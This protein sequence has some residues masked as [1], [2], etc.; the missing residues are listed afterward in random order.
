MAEHQEHTHNDP[1][2]AG[3][4]YDGIREYDNPIPGW[5]H[6]IFYGSVVFSLLYVMVVHMSPMWPTRNEA[7]DAAEERALEIQFAELRTFPMGEDKV[8]RIMGQ[9]KWL[10][11]GANIFE[12]NCALCHKADGSGMEG[13]GPNMTD[14]HYKNLTDLAGMLDVLENGAG[15]GAMPPNG[16]AQLNDNEVAL[17]VAYVASLRGKNLPG[18]APEGEIIAPFPE[19]ITNDTPAD[20]P[21][22]SNETSARAG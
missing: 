22:M 12:A 21:T 10:E 3:H 11:M 4:M 6:A 1:D 19:P 15:N 5:W 9:P 2:M 14:E 16:G 18:V 20:T 17:V 8:L 13:L 7:Y